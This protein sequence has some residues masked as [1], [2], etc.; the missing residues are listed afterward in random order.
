VREDDPAAFAEILALALLSLSH[1]C[2]PSLRCFLFQ[3]RSITPG[4][5]SRATITYS[6]G[7][8]RRQNDRR[9]PAPPR[10]SFSTFNC[11]PWIVSGPRLCRNEQHKKRFSV[12][13]A[14]PSE[15]STMCAHSNSP[16]HL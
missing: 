2:V 13:M 14:P 16:R 6:P 4:R 12:A 7:P 3:S 5:L 8:V 10:V 1:S 9:S 11:F 15:A